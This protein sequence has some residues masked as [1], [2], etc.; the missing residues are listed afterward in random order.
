M[1]VVVV[2]K[3]LVLI[4]TA[5]KFSSISTILSCKSDVGVT[6]RVSHS[7]NNLKTQIKKL[8]LWTDAKSIKSKSN[9]CKILVLSSTELQ[10]SRSKTTHKSF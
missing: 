3:D 6:L 8:K 2:V 9:Y 7:L 5:A 4:P 1:V 10:S